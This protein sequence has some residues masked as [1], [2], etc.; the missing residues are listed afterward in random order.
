MGWLGSRCQMT[1]LRSPNQCREEHSPEATSFHHQIPGLHLKSHLWP[2]PEVS[3]STMWHLVDHL[4]WPCWLKGASF[5]A[6]YLNSNL[7]VRRHSKSTSQHVPLEADG[8]LRC[9]AGDT[10]AVAS[11]QSGLHLQHED[12][13]LHPTADCGETLT[14][15]SLLNVRFVVLH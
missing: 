14:F 3:G 9:G 11:F 10:L 4:S 7:T 13:T 8:L 2:C 1:C 6:L 5:A 12:V 15:I